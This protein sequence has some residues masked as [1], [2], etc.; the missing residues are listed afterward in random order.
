MKKL[1]SAMLGVLLFTSVALGATW[2]A[3]TS[4][5]Q[6]ASANIY[7]SASYIASLHVITD[8]TNDAVV[9]LYDS[10]T[11]TTTHKIIEMTVVGADNYGGKV[12]KWPVKV[13]HG[14]YAT[15]SG[16]GASYVVE[17]ILP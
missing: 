11:T 16:T 15:V 1:L 7:A 2:Y 8:G 13:N 5:E 6:T 12:W 9:N 4:Y 17:Y 3:L 14:I 10:A